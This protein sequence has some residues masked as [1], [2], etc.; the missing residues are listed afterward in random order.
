MQQKRRK[1]REK[2]F[3]YKSLSTPTKLTCENSSDGQRLS[4]LGWSKEREGKKKKS[5]TKGQEKKGEEIAQ[6]YN[7][8]SHKHSANLKL[9]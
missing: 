3:I 8:K 1:R 9:G 5:G 7:T 4:R 2:N 6:A